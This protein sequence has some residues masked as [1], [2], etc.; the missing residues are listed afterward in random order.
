MARRLVV[1]LLLLAAASAA[2]AKKLIAF[3]D[4]ITDNGNGT[5]KF[6][7]AY[8]SQLLNQPVTAFYP[9]GPFFDHGRWSN[10]P[11]WVEYLTDMTG[12]ELNDQAVGSSVT[13]R[14][15]SYHGVGD[16]YPSSL[17][18]NKKGARNVTL[19]LFSDSIAAYVKSNTITAEDVV[20]VEIGVNDLLGFFEANLVQTL[21]FVEEATVTGGSYPTYIIDNISK[22]ISDGLTTLYT[23][24]ARKFIVWQTPAGES[25]PLVNTINELLN[26]VNFILRGLGAVDA[27]TNAVK[28]YTKGFVDLANAAISNL[29]AIFAA[30]HTDAQ[31]VVFPFADVQRQL[32]A[33]YDSMGF[34]NAGSGCTSDLAITQY[35]TGNL[36]S[37]GNPT[38]TSEGAKATLT[39][40][41]LFVNKLNKLGSD[42]NGS[43][44][45][46]NVP[47]S[48]A[49]FLQRL[50]DVLATYVDDSNTIGHITG[51][52]LTSL[53]LGRGGWSPYSVVP[54]C[55]L[56]AGDHLFHDEVHPTT[57]QHALLAQAVMK[58]AGHLFT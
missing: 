10:G 14:S 37:L 13:N 25:V 9:P 18:S 41:P 48:T 44:G 55:I 49:D 17:L 2:S 40:S 30:A 42:L 33:S 50:K 51:Y 32:I 7:Q 54:T 20:V 5:N 15:I 29:A 23:A 22:A 46:Q 19:P 16:F 27:Q 31:V 57:R 4:S 35:S 6:V 38:F 12:Y 11:V 36:Y 28:I 34:V 56:Q 58:V 45:R 3:G 39:L 21:E 8:Y 43:N 53:P 26:M 24:G 47:S 1:L 52:I